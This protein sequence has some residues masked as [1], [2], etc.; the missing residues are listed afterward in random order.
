MQ[1]CLVRLIEQPKQTPKSS[2]HDQPSR[3]VRAGR[4]TLYPN[5]KKQLNLTETKSG[6]LDHHTHQINIKQ[7]VI[8]KSA[9]RLTDDSS[10]WRWNGGRAR[11]QCPTLSFWF[12]ISQTAFTWKG[13]RPSI[14]HRCTS[15]P[16]EGEHVT[17]T[18]FNSSQQGELGNCLH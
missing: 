15:W 1:S 6:K 4:L 11:A 14:S 17:I 18:Q 3:A 16:A 5:T 13:R 7:N 10:G 9:S 2:L 8:P 12:I